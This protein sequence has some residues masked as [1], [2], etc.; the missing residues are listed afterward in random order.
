MPLPSY[1]IPK[2]KRTI[3]IR[4]EIRRGKHNAIVVTEKKVFTI[5]VDI[6][7]EIRCIDTA[8]ESVIQPLPSLRLHLL[9]TR[10][11]SSHDRNSP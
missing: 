3:S 4:K 9:A 11:P 7:Y 10:I 6:F 1:T 8:L 2:I 5:K